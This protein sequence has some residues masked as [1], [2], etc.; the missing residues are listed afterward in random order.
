[1]FFVT[2]A[3][4]SAVIRFALRS[5]TPVPLL[6]G[7]PITKLALGLR[8]SSKSPCSVASDRKAAVVSKD[9]LRSGEDLEAIPV[10]LKG[11]KPPS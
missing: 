11:L 10:R 8:K 6:L 2:V 5:N 3:H 4:A 9:A 7:A 1:M